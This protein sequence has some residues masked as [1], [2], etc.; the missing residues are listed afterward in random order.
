[1]KQT[2]KQTN[3]QTKGQRAALS[4]SKAVVRQQQCLLPSQSETTQRVDCLHQALPT[5][6]RSALGQRNAL[7]G[8]ATHPVT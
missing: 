8:R 3:K 1:V 6:Q 7:I 2:D 5:I 4:L